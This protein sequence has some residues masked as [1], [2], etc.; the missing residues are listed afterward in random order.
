[1]YTYNA[2]VIR[3][4]DGDT[5][6]C[7][8]DLGFY[9]WMHDITFRLYGIDCPETRTRDLVEKEAGLR[10]KARVQELCPEGSLVRIKV[11]GQEKY[12]RWLATVYMLDKNI[13]SLNDLLISE[14]LA[15]HYTT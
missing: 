15:Q 11:H 13:I 8:V 6:N 9:T 4:I 7:D 1:M 14:G 3:V 2:R 5:I 12:G 10:S